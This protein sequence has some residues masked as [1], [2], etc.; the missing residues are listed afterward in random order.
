[1]KE[2]IEILTRLNKTIATMESCTGGGIANAI[3]NVEGSSEVLKFSAVTYAN[4]YK[5]KMG[6]SKDVIDQYSV[7][8]IEV[9]NEMSKK[10][11]DF[12]QADYGIG[13]TGKLNRVDK[14]NL[15]GQDNLVY[16]SIYD[17]DNNQFYNMSIKV[18][19]ISRQENKDLV[20]EKIINELKKILN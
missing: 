9:A 10:I 3:T 17:R 6:V 11:S 19:M 2:I 18:T 16:I 8:S 15:S 14:H 12:A 20:I 5:I 13:V 7:Y 4:E 1:M